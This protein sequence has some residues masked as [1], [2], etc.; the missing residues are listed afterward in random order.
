M[1][2][3]AKSL[4]RLSLMGNIFKKIGNFSITE[5]DIF[6]KLY[7][8]KTLDLRH[9]Q[10]EA[11]GNE[12]FNKLTALEKLI[13]SYNK[14]RRIEAT[15]L[16]LNTL[17]HLDISY[18]F[19]IP[20]DNEQ[21]PGRIDPFLSFVD[22]L[23]LKNG[24]FENVKNLKFLD[25]SHTKLHAYSGI[26]L[27]YL[28][29]ELEQL[30]LCYTQIP[31]ITDRMFNQTKLKVL[32]LS[33]N[34]GL[35]ANFGNSS[36]GGLENKLEMFAFENAYVKH[37]HWISAL[38]R[39]TILKLW[40]NNI[41]SV[42]HTVFSQLQNLKIV[43]LGSNHI[44]HWYERIISNITIDVLD[45]RNNNINVISK[46]MIKDFENV[47]YLAIGRNNFICN[48]I[49]RDFLEVAASNTK[50][51]Q[52]LP[53]QQ[54]R[55]AIDNDEYQNYDAYSRIL[56]EYLVELD[57]H[58]EGILNLNTYY[59][60]PKNFKI[61]N[62]SQKTITRSS[63]LVQKN[64][65]CANFNKSKPTEYKMILQLLDYTDND[66][67]CINSNSTEEFHIAE[68]KLCNHFDKTYPIVDEI[69]K[70]VLIL[71]PILVILSVGMLALF[72]YYRGYDVKYFCLNFRNITVLSLLDK[73]KRKL[74]QKRKNVDPEEY[75]Y[76]VFVSYSEQNRSWILDHLL[77]NIEQRNDI[78]VCLH[79]RDFKVIRKTFFY[80]VNF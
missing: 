16:V 31:I 11:I 77:P 56:N 46:E 68:L 21:Y 43:D 2:I 14:I 74:L 66:Y 65:Y 48:C 78:N 53:T 63:L 27:A 33:G 30:S 26:A 13:L 42:P 4:Q 60:G 70:D 15:A 36:L 80:N 59:K 71:Y 55:D 40:K 47:R 5:S 9:C 8:L 32:D 67:K 57:E 64:I 39:L 73:D 52:C 61:Y 23:F 22:G 58:R 6:P 41:N 18:N 37:I 3:V 20:G 10:I 54:N 24:I 62:S 38:K 34:Q 28:G 44:G 51:M 19:N 49:L 75:V 25:L 45:L 79:E 76:D 7:K 50:S 12:S 35:A 1:T 17:Q 29:A 69:P 72:I